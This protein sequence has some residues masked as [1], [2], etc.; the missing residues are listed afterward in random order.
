MLQPVE[1]HSPWAACLFI[2]CILRRVYYDKYVNA[3]VL[4]CDQQ[5][6]KTIL[7]EYGKLRQA[8]HRTSD[9]QHIES[10]RSDAFLYTCVCVFNIS[11][12]VIQT[13]N[14]RNL[15]CFILCLSVRNLVCHFRKYETSPNV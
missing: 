3:E 8:K 10:I 7:V 1:C 11:H 12:L 9:R 15:V 13:R 2:V 14:H 4:M 5:A 6:A